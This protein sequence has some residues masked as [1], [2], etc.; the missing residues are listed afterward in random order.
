MG[1]IKMSDVVISYCSICGERLSMTHYERGFFPCKKCIVLFD[2]AEE[3]I[4]GFAM[5]SRP[6]RFR[7]GLSSGEGSACE[8]DLEDYK[9]TLKYTGWQG[10]LND[11]G[12]YDFRE[13]WRY[14]LA[15]LKRIYRG[16]VNGN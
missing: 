16:T 11:K 5:V 7:G 9:Y 3:G 12:R 10:R 2:E 15:R 4:L 13:G 8:A 6:E 14:M 1:E